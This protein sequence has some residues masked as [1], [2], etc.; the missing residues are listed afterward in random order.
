MATRRPVRSAGNPKRRSAQ[1]VRD[2]ARRPAR[3]VGESK[4]LSVPRDGGLADAEG[5]GREQVVQIQ[6]ARILDAMRDVAVELG[7]GNVSVAHVVERC[8]VSRRTFY[9]LF[10]DCDECLL[11]ALE[12]ATAR[13][14]AVVVPAYESEG[15]WHARVR[16]ALA[17]LLAF[18]ESAPSL[19]RLVVVESLAAGSPALERRNEV[20]AYAIAAVDAGR[21]EAHAGA[22]PDAL[23][24]EGVVGGVSAVIHARL[25]A[26]G[27]LDLLGLTNQLM[28]MVVLP[29]L[30]PAAARRELSRPTPKRTVPAAR[31]RNGGNPLHE[32]G[33]R[34]T[35]RTMRVLDSVASHPD[36]SN[37]LI[38]EMAGVT[39]QGQISKLLARLEHLGLLANG[40]GGAPA[41]GEPNEW[42]LTEIGEQVAHTISAHMGTNTD[43]AGSEHRGGP[44]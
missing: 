4:R 15:R 24:A 11:A 25:L 43:T 26:D 16:A 18:F 39:D 21:S 14:A 42:R 19:A 33:M 29:Y 2:Q 35:Y 23:T 13:I 37:R 44:A 1:S 41:R 9:E 27:P 10:S 8:G 6:R 20:F 22:Q 28:V 30:G 3:E 5:F 40:A 36:A 31:E 17:E 12:D 38:G 34:L 32:L 7:A